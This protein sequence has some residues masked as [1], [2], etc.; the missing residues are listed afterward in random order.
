M[1]IKKSDFLLNFLMFCLGAT[2]GCQIGNYLAA[3]SAASMLMNLPHLE[4]TRKISVLRRTGI[5]KRV[6]PQK[7][8]HILH[9]KH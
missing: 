2:L 5:F 1:T 9:D 7:G 8:V 6:C 3:K 4:L